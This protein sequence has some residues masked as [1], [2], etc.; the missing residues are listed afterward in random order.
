MIAFMVFIGYHYKEL[1]GAECSC[2]PWIK[3][4]VGPGFFVGDGIMLLLAI[5]AGIGV[6]SSAG[7]RR[8]ATIL[9]GIAAVYSGL[10]RI[11]SDAAYRHQSARYPHGRGRASDIAST[12]VRFLS[13]SSIRSACTASMRG[14]NWRR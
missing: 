7:L 3:R 10:V 5:A 2:F 8:A 11:R 6:R 4:A 13:I 12:R 14:G 1:T 9:A